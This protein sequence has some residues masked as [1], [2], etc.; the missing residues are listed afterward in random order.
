MVRNGAE[1]IAGVDLREATAAAGS[2][3]GVVV[4]RGRFAG[5]P[6]DFFALRPLDFDRGQT[7]KQGTRKIAL[8]SNSGLAE[9]L[10]DDNVRQKLC[11]RGR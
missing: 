6:G 3:Q 8:S 9:S 1:H 7:E 4:Y 11:Q 10:F 5:G 2:Q